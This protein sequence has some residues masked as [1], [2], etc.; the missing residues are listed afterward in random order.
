MRERVEVASS[1]VGRDP[2]SIDIVAV[3]KFHPVEAV[4]A[5]VACGI[6]RFAESRVQEAEGKFEGIGAVRS[7]FRLDLIGHLQ[8][9][10]VRRALHLFDRIQSV[11]SMDI[12]EKIVSGASV[13]AET[14]KSGT[15]ELLFELH[16]AEDSKSGFPDVDALR[17]AVESIIGLP[18]QVGVSLRGLMT[19]APFGAGEIKIRASF[20]T[21]RRLQERLMAE[22]SI[23]Q[24]D[25]LSM[26]MSGDF[27]IAVEEGATEIRIGTALFGER[28]S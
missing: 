1:R 11:D 4:E 6:R 19:V 7:E 17:R 26:G 21:L 22:F 28:K 12:L 25:V 14:E 8:S 15:T 2:S 27:E 9:N 3:S 5:A 24:F 18:R 10:K 13:K 23:P 16:T 20:G